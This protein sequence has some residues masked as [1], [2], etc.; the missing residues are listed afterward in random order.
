MT[1]FNVTSGAFPNNPASLAELGQII[2]NLEAEGGEQIGG[3]TPDI[4]AAL[5]AIEEAIV[6]TPAVTAAD[7]A[8]LL[9]RLARAEE[10]GWS[11]EAK[12]PLVEALA[13]AYEAEFAD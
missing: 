12:A 6:E 7:R 5:D 4:V 1:C 8:W 2:D 13:A 11:I 10:N 3:P 9:Q